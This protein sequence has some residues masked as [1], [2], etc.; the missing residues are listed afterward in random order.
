MRRDD[1]TAVAEPLA[2][3]DELTL[4]F[5]PAQQIAIQQYVERREREL[6]ARLRTQHR[7]GQ[8]FICSARREVLSSHARK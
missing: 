5:T 7:R 3:V 2:N 6:V 4:H 8:I 1:Q